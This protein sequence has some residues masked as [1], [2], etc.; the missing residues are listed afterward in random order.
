[1]LADGSNIN[2]FLPFPI[3]K[4]YKVTNATARIYLRLLKENKIPPR[5]ASMIGSLTAEM[6]EQLT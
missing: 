2:N 6:K 1:M 5:A 4:T 3:E